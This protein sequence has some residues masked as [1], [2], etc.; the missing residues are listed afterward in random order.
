MDQI[1]TVLGLAFGKVSPFAAFLSGVLISVKYGHAGKPQ[2]LWLVS[3]PVGAAAI[4]FFLGLCSYECNDRPELT[5][6]D[7]LQN[8][9]GMFAALGF[10][11]MNFIRLQDSIAAGVSHYWHRS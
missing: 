8:Y 6:M 7:S 9:L 5:Y 4:Q 11:G 10:C 2:W 1:L 3:F